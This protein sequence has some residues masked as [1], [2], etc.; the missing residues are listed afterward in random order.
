ME[1]KLDKVL[2]RQSILIGVIIL[3]AAALMLC[4]TT[5][6][7]LNTR[8]TQMQNTVSQLDSKT[9]REIQNGLSQMQNI[10]DQQASMLADGRIVVG[11]LET[12]G[13]E[14]TTTVDLSVVPKQV[15]P[16]AVVT[17]RLLDDSYPD[18]NMTLPAKLSEDGL[19][20]KASASIPLIEQLR[21]QMIVEKNGVKTVEYLPWYEP[22]R[23]RF[24]LG[25]NASRSGTSR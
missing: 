24:L 20:Y 25:V 21:V 18:W 17:I 8:L 13:E 16:G 3:L 5:V 23:D 6:N 14:L 22:I 10:L 7:G 12:E 15:S 1:E 9:Q 19:T 2:K 4:W 11:S